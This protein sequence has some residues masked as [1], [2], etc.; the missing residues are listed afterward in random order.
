MEELADIVIVAARETR[1]RKVVSGSQLAQVAEKSAWWIHN[2][3]TSTR[4]S[5]FDNVLAAVVRL[6]DSL[7]K[8]SGI[9]A[10]V[11]ARARKVQLSPDWD[12]QSAKPVAA[13]RAIGRLMAAYPYGYPA[14]DLSGEFP[15]QLS[16]DWY[17][18]VD[19]LGAFKSL[20][21][22][23]GQKKGI[24][25]KV[26]DDDA[27]RILAYMLK[28]AVDAG[29]LHPDITEVVLRWLPQTDPPQVG[30]QGSDMISAITQS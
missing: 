19:E 13:I 24:W 1:E 21:A 5:H 29:C 30:P 16:D 9:V 27:M 23:M 18:R 2:V 25:W 26:K 12:Q 11:G 6:H 7:G 17:N 3:P 20:F 4:D 10:D 8:V 15:E 28:V 14:R 22:Q